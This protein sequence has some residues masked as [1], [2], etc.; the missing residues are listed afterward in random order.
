MLVSDYQKNPRVFEKNIKSIY[1]CKIQITMKR[2]KDLIIF[3]E[4]TAKPMNDQSSNVNTSKALD[5]HCKHNYTK[6]LN[7]YNNVAL[8]FAKTSLPFK[9]NVDN[10]FHKKKEAPVYITMAQV[11]V[12]SKNILKDG[13]KNDGVNF[14]NN[15][16]ANLNNES[17]IRQIEEE[18]I[19]V[20]KIKRKKRWEGISDSKER[21]KN[22]YIS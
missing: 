14:L 15:S 4:N 10:Y 12:A 1:F 9:D 19:T 16:S 5:N 13:I 8:I 3:W 17:I 18:K 11:Y 20:K 2:V 22:L 7:I 21:L 6:P